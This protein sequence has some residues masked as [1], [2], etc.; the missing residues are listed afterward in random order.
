MTLIV[1][2]LKMPIL[3]SQKGLEISGGRGGGVV[4][5]AKNF[6]EMNGWRDV[7]KKPFCGGWAYGYFRE[8]HINGSFT[9]L[10]QGFLHS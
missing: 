6:K 2:F 9:V 8:P 4:S 1:W 7:S 10:P 5:K 3:P